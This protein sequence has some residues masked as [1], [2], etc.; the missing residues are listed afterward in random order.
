MRTT[1]RS[2]AEVAGVD[3]SMEIEET[4]DAVI[5]HLGGPDREFFF[6]EDGDVLRALEHLLQRIASRGLEPRRLVIE[7]EGYRERRDAALSA[8]ARELAAEVRQDGRSRLTD[9]LNSYERR[10][11]HLALTDEPGVHT[12]SVGEGIDRR[13]TIAPANGHDDEGS[14]RG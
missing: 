4:P 14:S 10:I 1:L 7:C 13:V 6:E 2:L 11:V 8:L 9:P 5:V 12:F 3:V